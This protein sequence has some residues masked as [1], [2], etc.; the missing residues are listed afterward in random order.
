MTKARL[1]KACS[2][3]VSGVC[4]LGICGFFLCA[5]ALCYA[6]SVE[7]HRH[8]TASTMASYSERYP[9]HDAATR[10]DIE[11]V[12]RLLKSGMHVD[13]KDDRGLTPLHCACW[14]DV[15]GL[16][17]VCKLLLNS[18]ASVY[19]TTTDTHSTPLHFCCSISYTVTC[20]GRPK[21]IN[22]FGNCLLLNPFEDLSLAEQSRELSRTQ[23]QLMLI[24]SRLEIM[25]LLFSNGADPN[26]RNSKY[27]S[28][29]HV[30]AVSGGAGVLV[31]ML[32]DHGAIADAVEQYGE[33]PLGIATRVGSGDSL[34][35]VARVLVE[36]GTADVNV[37]LGETGDTPLHRAVYKNNRDLLCMLLDHGGD[38]SV[39]N[40][41]G[42]GLLHVVAR[43]DFHDL[44]R[45]LIADR[46]ADA[47]SLDK[48]GATALHCAA[49]WGNWSTLKVL[50]QLG[51]DHRMR[52]DADGSTALDF[53]STQGHFDCVNVI[54]DYLLNWYYL[55]PVRLLLLRMSEWFVTDLLYL[56]DTILSFV[57]FTR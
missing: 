27:A 38:L 30:A 13:N 24:N 40:K 1:I 57:T 9:L 26:A 32:L 41:R 39:Q 52:K 47:N 31:K 14:S 18:G 23:Q 20:S 16:E 37:N 28:P 48:V 54:H 55:L 34:M 35:E 11:A 49:Y 50:L 51:G 5:P 7:Q 43:N 33:T 19:A 36:S 8:F 10:G 29:L 22:Y 45:Y 4:L 42:Y 21:G 44:A 53:A 17:G 56:E 6:L 3:Q 25:R 46:G 2:N 12:S 15:L